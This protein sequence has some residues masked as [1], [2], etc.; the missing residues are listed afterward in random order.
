MSKID[1]LDIKIRHLDG[2]FRAFAYNNQ[3]A[4]GNERDLSINLFHPPEKGGFDW[5]KTEEGF[6][7]WYAV[8]NQD[9]AEAVKIYQGT[10]NILLVENNGITLKLTS[11]PE[12]KGVKTFDLTNIMNM[13]N[14]LETLEEYSEL[15]YL[16]YTINS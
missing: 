12:R 11:Y 14:I 15:G 6:D 8:A 7:F 2:F 10:S 4:Q 3:Q 5:D 9:F 16:I 13:S 1:M